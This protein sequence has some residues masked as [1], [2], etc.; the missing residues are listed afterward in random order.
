MPDSETERC[1]MCIGKGFCS[2]WKHKFWNNF[3]SGAELLCS[4]VKVEC[5]VSDRFL[6]RSGTSLNSS[7]GAE[8]ATGPPVSKW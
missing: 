3:C 5:P 2:H 7:V 6:K 8:I 4:A 1:K